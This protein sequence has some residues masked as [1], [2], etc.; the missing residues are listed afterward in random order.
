MTQYTED[1][2]RQQYREK[3]RCRVYS[4]LLR[5]VLTTKQGSFHPGPGKKVS[6]TS[7]IASYLSISPMILERELPFLDVYRKMACDPDKVS[8]GAGNAME[9]REGLQLTSW[10]DGHVSLTCMAEALSAT[11]LYGICRVITYRGVE[12]LRMPGVPNTWRVRAYHLL[13]AEEII[14]SAVFLKQLE[15]QPTLVVDPSDFAVTAPMFTFLGHPPAAPFAHAS[16]TPTVVCE[17]LLATS[18]FSLAPS[19]ASVCFSHAS[20]TP[21]VVCKQVL[22]SLAPSCASVC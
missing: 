1:I 14:R 7:T 4:K 17:Q 20:Y 12:Y 16:Y 21:N 2:E 5:K 15:K 10:N 6:Q 8:R 22:A 13:G 18:L 9:S 3:D 19:C 11:W